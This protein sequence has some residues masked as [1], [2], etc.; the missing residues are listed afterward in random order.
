MQPSQQKCCHLGLKGKEIGQNEVF[1]GGISIPFDLAF[2][3]LAMH[4]LNGRIRK[5]LLTSPL[6]HSQNSELFRVG[7]VLIARSRSSVGHTHFLKIPNA[8]D[9]VILRP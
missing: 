9:K 3:I 6:T 7:L 8:S 4:P 5:Q 1:S 2:T